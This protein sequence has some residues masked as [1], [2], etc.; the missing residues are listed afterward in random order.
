MFSAFTCYDYEEDYDGGIASDTVVKDT[1][2]TVMT[3]KNLPAD[4]WAD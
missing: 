3:I 1:T 4:E 2:D